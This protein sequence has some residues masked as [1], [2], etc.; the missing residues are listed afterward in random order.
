MAA[1][2]CFLLMVLCDMGDVHASVQRITHVLCFVD[3]RND[4]HPWLKFVRRPRIMLHLP[5]PV[6]PLEGLQKYL[7]HRCFMFP[8][9]LQPLLL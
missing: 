6:W 1:A 4:I 9:L 3:Y 8:C 2:Q 5:L 7:L